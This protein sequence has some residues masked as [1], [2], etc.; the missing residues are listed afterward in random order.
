M[1]N[2]LV[3]V[4]IAARDSP[5]LPAVLGSL[6]CQSYENF[7]V[8]VIDDGSIEPIKIAPSS[9]GDRVTL[10][11]LENSVGRSEARNLG[12]G[13]SK[14]K[15]VVIHDAD[16]LSSPERIEWSVGALERNSEL[17]AVSGQFFTF[18]KHGVYRG[19]RWPTDSE[20]IRNGLSEGRMRLAH[21][22][23]TILKSAIEDAGGYKPSLERAE[24]YD[25]FVRLSALGRM[26]ASSEYLLAYSHPRI[27]SASSF[28][29]DYAWRQAA[30]RKQYSMSNRYRA[31]GYVRYPLY[32]AK[33]LATRRPLQLQ[34]T[35]LWWQRYCLELGSP[36]W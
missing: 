22:A 11:R 21:P 29:S 6:D 15:Y 24:D 10:V 2:P 28:S 14:G 13:K 16:D 17:V 4:L 1:P 25:L 31:A 23:A 19:P 35:P 7:E 5:T 30:V 36:P 3:T 8:V 32:S 26:Q 34:D 12:L 18:D 20:S 27:E 33:L 9:T